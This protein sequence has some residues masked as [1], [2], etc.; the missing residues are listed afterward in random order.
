MFDGG[1]I[2]DVSRLSDDELRAIA[3]AKFRIDRQKSFEKLKNYWPQEVFLEFHTASA[4]YRERGCL[5][6]NQVGKTS[7]ICAEIAMHATGIYPPWWK[8]RRFHHPVTI[9]VV[10]RT[11]LLNRDKLQVMLVGAPEGELG[12]GF[13][14]LHTIIASGITRNQVKG[15]YESVPVLHITGGE[16]RILF[17]AAEQGRANLQSLTVHA[18]YF[19]EEPPSDLYFEILS[20]TN[21]IEGPMTSVFTPLEGMT[22]IVGRFWGSAKEK[23]AYCLQF[24]LDQCELYSEDHK[25]RMIALYPEHE[26]EARAFGRPVFGSGLVFP[27]AW[28]T[29]SIDPLPSLPG[30]WARIGGLDF[31]WDHP[32]AATWAAWDRD[33]DIWYLTDEHVESH[34][35]TLY[36]AEAIKRRPRWI[37]MAW[38]HDG[39][40]MNDQT[41]IQLAESYRAH[42]VNMLAEHATHEETGVPNENQK[43]VTS[44]ESGLM[45]MLERMQTGRWKVYK[46]L[47]KWRDEY[48]TY[49]RKNGQVIKLN[50]DALSSSRYAFMMRRFAICEPKKVVVERAYQPNAWRT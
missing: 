22:P 20:R 24:S 37:P 50:D 26:R 11:M 28:E 40:K 3:L 12:T 23:T 4:T 44:V 2:E 47:T 35:L 41:G 15:G 36:H 8:G 46:T 33:S 7:A 14:P 38:P 49:H 6:P 30:H 18:A 43:S 10:G 48:Q 13:L 16:S 19:D 29:I 25:A 45:E 5:A 42:E 21:A 1:N 31:G 34:Q 17:R 27:V 39:Y 32:T 9:V